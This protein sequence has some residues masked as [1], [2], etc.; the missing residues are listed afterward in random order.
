M[1]YLFWTPT[2]VLQRI[3][4]HRC[5]VILYGINETADGVV[6]LLPHGTLGPSRY[7]SHLGERLLFVCNQYTETFC[8]FGYG[9]GCLLTVDQFQ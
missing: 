6:E 1:Q 5:S 7:P 2:K 9:L 4:E 8:Y 3:E